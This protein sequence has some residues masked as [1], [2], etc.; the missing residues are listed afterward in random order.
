MGYAEPDMLTAGTWEDLEVYAA[1]QGTVAATRDVLLRG[2][3]V[4][5]AAE[6]VESSREDARPSGAGA[7][8][9]DVALPAARSVPPEALRLWFTRAS[10][11]S[12]DELVYARRLA[13]T[14]AELRARER[15]EEALRRQD[16]E[17]ERTRRVVAALGVVTWNYDALTDVLT[18]DA[19]WPSLAGGPPGPRR[20]ADFLAHVHP[21]DRRGSSS[22][23]LRRK[24]ARFLPSMGEAL[25]RSTR[26]L[27]ADHSANF[28]P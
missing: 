24:G 5:L 2:A 16:E 14:L 12:A 27:S 26:R 22:P 25:P 9:I 1:G 7:L 23:S 17:T 19:V 6:I 20:L 4:L 10:A 3:A 15:L 28:V 11:W 21:A 8:A 13:R 18:L